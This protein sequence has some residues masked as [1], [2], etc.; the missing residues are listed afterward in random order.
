MIFKPHA[1][2]TLLQAFRK[3]WLTST[4]S[5][6][7]IRMSEHDGFFQVCKRVAT[8]YDNEREV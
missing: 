2:Q 3:R 4:T 5:K 8:I 1:L 7:D 6:R